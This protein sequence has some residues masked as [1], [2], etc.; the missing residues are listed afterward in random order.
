MK[1][2]IKT[3]GPYR[4]LRIE[5]ELEVISELVELQSLI[6][7]YI[8]LGI[9]HIAINFTESSYIYSGAIGVLVR[10]YK[11][12]KDE[13]GK[14]CIIEPKDTMVAVLKATGITK[15]IKTYKSEDDLPAKEEPRAQNPFE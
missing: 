15:I 9:K 10:C 6:E 7:G 13:G 14:L 12:I 8:K 5:E 11:Q 4:I 2:E 1:M 3:L